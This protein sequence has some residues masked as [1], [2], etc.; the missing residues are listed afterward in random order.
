[1]VEK[2]VAKLTGGAE[3]YRP[4]V[5]L[6][7][8]TNLPKTNP[9]MPD[10]INAFEKGLKYVA[11]L[12][13]W[14][15]EEQPLPKDFRYFDN[16]YRTDGIFAFHKNYH[17]HAVLLYLLNIIDLHPEIKSFVEKHFK[18]YQYW[19][20]YLIGHL[21]TYHDDDIYAW[22]MGQA[23]GF[24]FCKNWYSTKDITKQEITQA[25]KIVKLCRPYFDA[26]SK[27]IRQKLPEMLALKVVKDNMK[28]FKVHSKL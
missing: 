1:L 18:H 8:K 19:D 3:K 5:L 12:G 28:K 7:P 11:I 16:P 13:K 4:Q 17:A 25:K 26:M 15:L 20:G 23:L 6:D 2:N 9:R 10:E 22:Y 24:I 27:A 14:T 21:M